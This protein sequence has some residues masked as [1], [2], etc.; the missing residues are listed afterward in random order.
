MSK[1]IRRGDHVKVIAGN[2]KG[3]VGEVLGRSEE[4]ILVKGVNV[5]KKHLK[6]TQESQ[7]PR[8]VDMEVPV[9]ISNVMLCD[10]KGNAVKLSVE[11][12]ALV[13]QDTETKEK[14]VHRYLKKRG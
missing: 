3:K 2:D 8:I 10:E 6:R 5:R 12:K 14:K 4:R 7:G 1:R 13:Y 11:N 9:H